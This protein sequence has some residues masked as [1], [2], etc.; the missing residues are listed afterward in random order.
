MPFTGGTSPAPLT[1]GGGNAGTT[2]SATL[3]Q[4]VFESIAGA[5]GSLYDQTL[6]SAV[7]IQNMAY[8]RAIAFDGYGQLTRLVNNFFPGSL[9]VEGNLSRWENIFGVVPYS[10]DT[11]VMRNAR[12][13][14]KW[15][16]IG[17]T[18]GIQ[19]ITNVCNSLLGTRFNYIYL[20][21]PNA[22]NYGTLSAAW[23]YGQGI[24]SSTTSPWHSSISRIVIFV[25]FNSGLPANK[26]IQDLYST[27]GP[28]SQILQSIAP[29]WVTF[30]FSVLNSAGNPTFKLDDPHNLDFEVLS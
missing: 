26:Q 28:V 23:P 14:A 15:L 27:T 22:T 7:G 21:S 29:A 24:V 1:T 25:K 19:P 10:T 4:R 5:M 2:Q 16:S 9:T 12:I 13:S 18:N 6:N 3:L 30:Q 11:E 20:I 8:A 17:D